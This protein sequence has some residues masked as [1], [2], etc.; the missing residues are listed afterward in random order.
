MI[1]I[2]DLQDEFSLVIEYLQFSDYLSLRLVVRITGDKLTR[3]VE[4]S[5]KRGE[6]KFI[7]ANAN[8]EDL[9]FLGEMRRYGQEDSWSLRNDQVLIYKYPYYAYLWMKK[10]G[11]KECLEQTVFKDPYISY[12]WY[13]YINGEL[14][15]VYLKQCDKSIMSLKNYQEDGNVIIIDYIVRRV[16]NI[17]KVSRKHMSKISTYEQLYSDIMERLLLNNDER[18]ADI[19]SLLYTHQPS[20]I[21][22]YYYDIDYNP[23][24]C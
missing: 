21:D 1:H 11:R 22:V 15:E 10:F 24:L 4:R 19:L 12:Q 6:K 17:L 7:L 16:S 14:D 3:I 2:T 20:S 9:D 13:C 23:Y 18:V 8:C 5:K